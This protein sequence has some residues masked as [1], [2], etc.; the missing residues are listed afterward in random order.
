MLLDTIH[1]TISRRVLLNYRI[2]PDAAMRVLPAP[3]RPKLY[4]GHAVGGIC[5]IR[6]AEL[7]PRHV[8]DW[9]GFASENA[10]HRIAVE[11]ETNGERKEGVYIPQRNTAS[12]FNKTFGGRVFPGLFSMSEFQ[13]HES[14]DSVSI[15]V[16]NSDQTEEFAF[17]GSTA[18]AHATGS[19]F[20]TLA[21]AANFFSMGATGYSATLQPGRFEGMELRSLDWTVRPMSVT[22]AYSRFFARPEIFPK[23]TIDLDCA[24]IM[25]N[26]PHEWHSRPEIC[27]E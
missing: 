15:R 27:I 13:V 21:D 23:G 14:G 20:P 6:F 1:G 18:H 9:L 10:A 5:M 2:D 19:I 17:A 11:W 12:I 24:L 22:K 3:F 16:I 4:K 26:I 25:R 7:R 8:P